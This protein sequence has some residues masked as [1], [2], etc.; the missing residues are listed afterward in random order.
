M[1]VAFD[2]VVETPDKINTEAGDYPV[3]WSFETG[4]GHAAPVI[5]KGRYM[6]WIIMSP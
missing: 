6:Y 4:E 1:R 5:Y 2:N 3:V